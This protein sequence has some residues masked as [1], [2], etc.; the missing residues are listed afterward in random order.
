M[1]KLILIRA[2]HGTLPQKS[3]E[4]ECISRIAEEKVTGYEWEF[5]GTLSEFVSRWDGGASEVARGFR[6]VGTQH[7]AR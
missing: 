1:R 2:W 7:A 6:S 3:V 4:R 5:E